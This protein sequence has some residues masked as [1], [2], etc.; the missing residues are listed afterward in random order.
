MEITVTLNEE[1][2][3]DY[4]EFKENFDNGDL[5][6]GVDFNTLLAESVAEGIAEVNYSVSQVKKISKSN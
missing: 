1:Q 3:K 2:E 6:Q 4:K 5:R